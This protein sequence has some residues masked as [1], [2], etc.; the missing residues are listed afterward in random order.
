MKK[1]VIASLLALSAVAGSAYA[2]SIGVGGV[3]SSGAG[4]IGAAGQANGVIGGSNSGSLSGSFA[5]NEQRAYAASGTAVGLGGAVGGF[6]LTQP[7][8]P[9]FFVAG[10]GA[11]GGIASS[12]TAYNKNSTVGAS[13]GFNASTGNASGG[14]L[15]GQGGAA[16]GVAGAGSI[17]GVSF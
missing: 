13:G 6:G 3:A 10:A 1:I 14:Y 12:S 9:G 2:Q 15:A 4:V 16:G 17:I 8:N 5:G 7:G 11:V